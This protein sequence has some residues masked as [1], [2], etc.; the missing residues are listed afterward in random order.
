MAYLV[1]EKFKLSDLANLPQRRSGILIHEPDD[2]LSALYGHYLQAHNFDIKHCPHL[3]LLKD[4]LLA[5]N[6][7]V[8]ILNAESVG[9][10]SGDQIGGLNFRRDFPYLKVVTVGRDL[11]GDQVRRLM[12]AGV[13]SHINRK[14]SRPQDLVI[15]VQHLLAT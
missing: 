15:L 5:L 1:K 14:F 10:A 8:L 3:A 12:D 6:P 2:F 9:R 11:T 13:C 7:A 4:H